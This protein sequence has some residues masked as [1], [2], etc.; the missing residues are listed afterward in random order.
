MTHRHIL[1]IGASALLLLGAC[2]E[3]FSDRCRREAQEY[4]ERECPRLEGTN[5]IMDSMTYAS[6]PE[7][8]TYHYRLT[9]ELDDST[10]YTEELLQQFEEQMRTSLRQN[11]SLRPYKE[12]GFTFTYRYSSDRTGSL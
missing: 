3:S 8:F 12:R 7:G 1:L 2:T 9:G 4:T 10:M 6:E 5:V 11:I